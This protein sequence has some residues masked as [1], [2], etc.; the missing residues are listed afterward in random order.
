MTKPSGIISFNYA[1]STSSLFLPLPF[2]LFLCISSLPYSLT[3]LLKFLLR[4][5]RAIKKKKIP[6][7]SCKLSKS[8]IHTW[9]I[10][11][12]NKKTLREGSQ[13]HF[14]TCW[15]WQLYIMWSL[16]Y[17]ILVNV[18]QQI[19]LNVQEKHRALFQSTWAGIEL[20]LE[21][22]FWGECEK[23]IQVTQ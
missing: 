1:Y 11:I 18:L 15:E 23:W 3:S 13:E 14:W 9:S 5:K 17:M 10:C 4:K 2:S 20:G 6:N 8:V 16:C 22:T 21:M 19:I 12:K 7:T